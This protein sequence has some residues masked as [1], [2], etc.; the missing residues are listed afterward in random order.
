MPLF[1]FQCPKCGWWKEDIYAARASD[2]EANCGECGAQLV[3]R[4]YVNTQSTKTDIKCT[5]SGREFKSYNDLER[6]A[7]KNGKTV[8]STSE[9]EKD[10]MTKKSPDEKLKGQK[11]KFIREEIKKNVHKMRYG[12]DVRE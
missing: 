9:Y 8:V 1:D 6:W 11:S 7:R 5:Y 12:Y 10:H 4:P 3:W 2:I